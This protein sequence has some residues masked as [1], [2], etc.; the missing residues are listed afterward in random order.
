MSWLKPYLRTWYRQYP[1]SV[2]PT[3]QIAHYVKPLL[4]AH[5]E[6]RITAALAR[7]LAFTPPQFVSLPKF[8]ATFGAWGASNDVTPKPVRVAGC[9]VHPERPWVAEQNRQK[10]C[11]ECFDTITEDRIP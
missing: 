4:K 10:M 8:A 2:P 3:R 9:S 7:Y 11:R 5:P 1:D 6:S